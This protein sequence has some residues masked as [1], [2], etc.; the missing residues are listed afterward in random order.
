[1][2]VTIPGRRFAPDVT[3]WT[4]VSAIAVAVLTLSESLTQLFIGDRPALDSG[5]ELAEYVARTAF[6]NLL[7]I[8]TDTILMAVLIVFLGCF[9]QLV[10]HA[11][12]DL[13]WVADLGFGAGLVF[14]AVTLV[15]DAM[16]GGAA[17]DTIGL[18]PD[19]SA[20]RALT[21]GHILMFG[22]VGCVLT[23]LVAGSASYLT[24]ASHALPDWT[25]WIAGVA[26]VL[27]LLAVPTMFGGTDP[28]A[29]GAAGGWGTAALATFPWLIWVVA[30][31]IATIRGRRHPAVV[32]PPEPLAA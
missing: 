26:A 18:T 10:T 14:V 12:P 2:A 9:R 31:G 6:P 28:D 1:M 3:R 7:I 11:R 5:A 15:G 21:E 24:F 30:V 8:M 29:I 20:I 23:A 16:E 27:N 22:T 25:G 32:T 17:L 13:E 4:G 19:P